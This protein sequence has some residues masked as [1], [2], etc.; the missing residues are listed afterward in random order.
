MDEQERIICSAIYFNDGIKRVHQPINIR[1]GIVILGLRHCNC[2]A[3]AKEIFPN[4]ECIGNEI[5]GFLTNSNRFVKRKQAGLIAY[6][7]GQTK[8]KKGE[9]CSEDLY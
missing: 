8:E 5:Q 1:E 3:I 2:F 4:R 7:A 9:L 6:Q